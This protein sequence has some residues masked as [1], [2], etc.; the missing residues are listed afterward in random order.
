MRTINF[1]EDPK[2]KGGGVEF[3]R[4]FHLESRQKKERRK[5]KRKIGIQ[6]AAPV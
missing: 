1:K 6:R 3:A 4:V 5:R 2:K